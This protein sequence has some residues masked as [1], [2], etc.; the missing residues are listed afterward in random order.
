ML[1][2]SDALLFR[3]EDHLFVIQKYPYS[4]VNRRPEFLLIAELSEEY[5]RSLLASGAYPGAPAMLLAG[6][7]TLCS[8]HPDAQIERVPRISTG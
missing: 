3:V 6:G 4:S 8:T 5:L 2:A 1:S 7:Q